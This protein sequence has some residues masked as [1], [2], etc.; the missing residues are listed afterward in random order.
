MDA[1]AE[2]LL[3]EGDVL[4]PLGPH[5]TCTEKG[6]KFDKRKVNQ[7]ARTDLPDQIHT[8]Y[9]YLCLSQEE[10]CSYAYYFTI[11]KRKKKRY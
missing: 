7:R 6:D 10:A 4:C 8:P 5:A 2:S 11:R 9:L 3:E 1:A